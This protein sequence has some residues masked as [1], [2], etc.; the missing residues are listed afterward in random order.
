[1]ARLESKIKLDMD[2]L[3]LEKA[4]KRFWA[5]VNKIDDGCWLW[6]GYTREGYGRFSFRRKLVNAHYFAWEILHGTPVPSG[7]AHLLRQCGNKLCVN[8]DHMLLYQKTQLERFWEKV[9]KKENGC[10]EW[11]AY[12]MRL[13]YGMFTF[14]KIFQLAHRIA[15]KI[16]NGP[17]PE[18]LDVLH[19]CDNP[20]CCNPDHLFL[21]THKD[22]MQDCVSKGRIYRKLDVEDILQIR[23]RYAVEKITQRQLGEEYGVCQ[24]HI[25]DIIRRKKWR[26]I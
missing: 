5:K 9:E 2:E 6:T 20:P 1:M 24:V 16:T 12:K 18:G 19:R 3:Y 10:W 13:G 22:N 7:T 23:K 8:P 14:D 17:I 21:G 11:T 4:K 26:H 15:W 25:G